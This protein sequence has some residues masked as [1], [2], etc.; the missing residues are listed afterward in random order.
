M[1]PAAAPALPQLIPLLRAEDEY[2]AV[3]VYDALAEMGAA[4]RPAFPA[5]LAA[6]AVP[7][8]SPERILEPL[9]RVARACSAAGRPVELGETVAALTAAVDSTDSFWPEAALGALWS[10]GPEARAAARFL[11]DRTLDPW[12]SE[13]ERTRSADALLKVAPELRDSLLRGLR[14]QL[15]SAERKERR[16]AA[17]LLRHLEAAD[18]GVVLVCATELTLAKGE[19]E[20]EQAAQALLECGPVAAAEIGRLLSHPDANLTQ[21]R[22]LAARLG[23]Y[24]GTFARGEGVGVLRGALSHAD[25]LVRRGAALSL[26]WGASQA[27]FQLDGIVLDAAL[28]ELGDRVAREPR[29]LQGLGPRGVAALPALERALDAPTWRED[30]GEALQGIAALGSA[31]LPVAPRLR[32]LL[33]N[34]ESG[35]VWAAC[36]LLE[37]TPEDEARARAKLREWLP[38]LPREILGQVAERFGRERGSWQPS[39]RELALSQLERVLRYRGRLGEGEAEAL[40]AC[41]ALGARERVEAI[42]KDE[43]ASETLREAARELLK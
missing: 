17:T 30:R 28:R 23:D 14:R 3:D 29:L 27:E 26:A 4:A 31:A 40:R 41:L 22:A 35:C 18:R 12:L 20:R 13:E 15:A 7:N 34:E 1:G 24:R 2:L 16:G 42:A 38:H 25:E 5:M 21:A 6:R 9:T 33:T 11:L 39:D 8:F 43:G 19:H 32:R 10:L 37:L 36:V